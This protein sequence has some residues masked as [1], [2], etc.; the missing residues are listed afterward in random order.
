[1]KHG[2]EPTALRA[3]HS[4]EFNFE[5]EAGWHAE[6]GVLI[7]MSYELIWEK[8]FTVLI[9]AA[10]GWLVSAA[11]K[12]S[13]SKLEKTI[14][15]L[16]KRVISP[17]VTRLER[18]ES[19]SEGFATRNDVKEIVTDL[20]SAMEARQVEIRGTMNGIF[21][22]LREIREGEREKTEVRG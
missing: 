1:M 18:L 5:G 11:T 10:V 7:Q 17:L 21:R 20:K 19:K 15:E 16:E 14:A 6:P 8:L 4:L 2:S 12:V 22:E 9:S 3:V 13:N